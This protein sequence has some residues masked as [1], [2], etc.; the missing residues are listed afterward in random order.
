MA[1]VARHNLHAFLHHE[2]QKNRKLFKGM[3][4]YTSTKG[5]G[6]DMEKR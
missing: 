3:V 4:S 5:E 1:S 6:G 2:A